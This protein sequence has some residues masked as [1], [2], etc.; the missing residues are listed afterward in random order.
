[1]KHF[2][3]GLT[4]ESQIHRG[5]EFLGQEKGA[6]KRTGISELTHLANSALLTST[7]TMAFWALPPLAKRS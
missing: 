5:D 1:M 4:G 7:P 2:S 6:V 3:G